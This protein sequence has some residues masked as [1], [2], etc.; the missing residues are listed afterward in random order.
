MVPELYFTSLNGVLALTGG[1]GGCG[2]EYATTWPCETFFRSPA[3]WCTTTTPA[4]DPS[5]L[6]LQPAKKAPGGGAELRRRK[7]MSLVV[8]L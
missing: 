7:R 3:G 2:D 5:A 8:S 6:A 1:R 4:P